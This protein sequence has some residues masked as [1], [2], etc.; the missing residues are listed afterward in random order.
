MRRF[1]IAVLAI[2]LAGCSKVVK[3]SMSGNAYL[4]H[5]YS[6]KVVSEIKDERAKSFVETFKKNLKWEQYLTITDSDEYDALV[7]LEKFKISKKESW[8]IKAQF[9]IKEV[10]SS[11]VYNISVHCEVS[12]K[13]SS[14]KKAINLCGEKT[15]Y[16]WEYV[17]QLPEDAYSGKIN[18]LPADSADANP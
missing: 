9:E 10:G 7:K 5:T 11:S 2:L 4:P 18:V 13:I 17:T 14:E 8:I 1:F 6:I 3:I 12:S 16:N 15:S